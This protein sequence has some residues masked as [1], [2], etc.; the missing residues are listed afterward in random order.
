MSSSNGDPLAHGAVVWQRYSVATIAAI[1]SFG[2]LLA[3]QEARA[4]MKRAEHNVEGQPLKRLKSTATLQATEGEDV[5]GQPCKRLKSTADPRSSTP[6][7]WQR[8]RRTRSE[9]VQRPAGLLN[10][11]EKRACHL[12]SS[13]WTPPVHAPFRPGMYAIPS[14]APC[15]ST[16]QASSVTAQP[17][18]EGVW[19]AG[20]DRKQVHRRCT[21]VARATAD[22]GGGWPAGVYRKLLHRRCTAVA[23]AT[24]GDADGDVIPTTPPA[25]AQLRL[26][27]V[28]HRRR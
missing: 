8:H 12:A 15:A 1:R 3:Q 28:R 25:A 2:E 20:V 11:A 23:R 24:A 13:R 21:A 18:S 7:Q 10:E 17:N 4:S 9:L 26:H 27:Q 19:P 14:S 5:E 6:Q 22:D 16:A